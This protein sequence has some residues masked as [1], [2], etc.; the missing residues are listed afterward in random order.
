MRK[1]ALGKTG[2]EVSELA[3]GTWGLSGDA[4]GPLPDVEV[5][6]TIDRAVAVGITLFDTA[7]AYGRGD[8][9]RKLG[10]RLPAAKTQV[11]TK[12]G[13]S[14][15]GY[16]EKKFDKQTLYMAFERSQERL[17]RD[18]VEVVL[19][20]NP[21][22]VTLAQDEP[23]ELLERLKSEGRIRTWGVSANTKEIAERAI[24]RGAEVLEMP[25]NCFFFRDVQDLAPRLRNEGIALLARSVLSYGL[26]SGHWSVEREFYPPDHRAD[27]W[28]PDELKRRIEQ[29]EALRKVKGGPAPTVRSVAVRWVLENDRVSSAVLGP[30][31]VTQLDQLV[32]EAGRMP[33]Y[34]SKGT[35]AKLE[36]ELAALGVTGQ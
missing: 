14:L 36:V 26:L 31:N 4:Y 16:P 21:S 33:P 13:T 18:V 10:R 12:L 24:D 23:I 9:E 25:Y 20:H 6:R 5:D 11:V 32:R 1:R 27:R 35:V 15:D 17:K 19:L 8:M 30:K 29:L 3:L 22:L 7:D 28:N 34:L 2:L